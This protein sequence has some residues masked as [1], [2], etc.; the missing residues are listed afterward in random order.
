MKNSIRQNPCSSVAN[1][2]PGLRP[3]IKSADNPNKAT[4]EYAIQ[5]N[6]N[7]I[8]VFGGKW[9]TARQLGL[10]VAGLVT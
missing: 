3:L 6:Q 1:K 7:V 8:T 2:Q 4:R 9:T 10:K 5:Q